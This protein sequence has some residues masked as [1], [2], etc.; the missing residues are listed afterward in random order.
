MYDDELN[1]RIILEDEE[2]IEDD[3]AVDDLPFGLL[4][5]ALILFDELSS[6]E[7]QYFFTEV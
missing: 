3:E 1:L 2:V 4:I 5:V 6:T 7:G